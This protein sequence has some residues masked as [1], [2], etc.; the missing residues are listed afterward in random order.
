MVNFNGKKYMYI[1][2][3]IE[4]KWKISMESLPL[5]LEIYTFNIYFPSEG[6]TPEVY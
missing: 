6:I 5:G 4:D 2:I 1:F 3:E